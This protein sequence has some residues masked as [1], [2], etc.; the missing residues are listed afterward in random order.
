M[1]RL[2]EFDR[3]KALESAML[4]FWRQGYNV[5]S[6]S[7]LLEAMA[8]S[9][10]SFYAAFIDKRSIYIEAL[11]LFSQRTNSVLL[12][13]ADDRN[14]GNAIKNFF[15]HTLF[16]VPERRMRRGCM[17]VNTVLELADVDQGLSILASQKLDEIERAFEV[18]FERALESGT[19][20]SQQT[21]K[22]LAQFVMTINQGLRVSSRKDI[23]KK[24]LQNIL[25]T[26]T[27]VLG[28]AA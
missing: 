19:F 6:L 16:S 22:E 14:P 8:I 7:Q 15:E 24:D 11:T 23:S 27:A 12:S 10:S 1:A 18:C 13:V 9:R 4:L 28:L 26:T 20:S 5:T 3:H 17:M 21:A 2:I 25:T